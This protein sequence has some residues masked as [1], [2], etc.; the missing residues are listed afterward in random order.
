LFFRLLSSICILLF[1]WRKAGYLKITGVR[2]R[3]VE[4]RGDEGSLPAVR[5]KA[6]RPGCR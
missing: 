5:F 4:W 3:V 1:K 6:T 2:T